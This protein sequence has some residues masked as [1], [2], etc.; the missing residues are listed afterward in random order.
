MDKEC[1]KVAAY[2]IIALFVIAGFSLWDSESTI[3]GA[4][5][6][7]SSPYRMCLYKYGRD[8]QGNLDWEKIKECREM[9]E[10]MEKGGADEPRLYF[11]SDR[12]AYQ[13][14]E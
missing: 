10:E 11:S 1:M 8:A 14:E 6:G 3:I 5:T 13:N 7:K 9:Y 12:S 4:V 2:A